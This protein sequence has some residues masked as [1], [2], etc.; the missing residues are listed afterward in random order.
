MNKTV[1]TGASILAL[2]MA[3]AAFAQSAPTAPA[4][5]TSPPTTAPTPDCTGTSNNCSNVTQDGS[6]LYATVD[7]SGEGNTSDIDQINGSVGDPTRDLG[8]VVT[9]SGTD[10]QS[11]VLQDNT[12]GANNPSQVTV[13]QDGTG[14]DS[15]VIQFESSND[16]VDVRQTGDNTSL[17]Y[18]D[19]APFGS[20][21]RVEI[22]Q[23]GGDLNTSTVFQLNTNRSSVGSPGGPDNGVIQNG[24]RNDSEVYQ[25]VS[26]ATGFNFLQAKVI[27]TGDD[28]NSFISQSNSG[29]VN[30]N[31]GVFPNVTAAQVEQVGNFNISSVVQTGARGGQS[32]GNLNVGVLQDG[33]DNLSRIEQT[34]VSSINSQASIA[35]VTQ[36]QDGND[37]FI[38]QSSGSG[39][40]NVTQTSDD[41]SGMVSG[42]AVAN[43]I[44]GGTDDVRANFSRVI[45]S[46]T[47]RTEAT[48]TQTGLG[49]LSDIRQNA[50]GTVAD[51]ASQA[52]VTQNGEDQSSFI[53]QNGTNDIA[54]VDQIGGARNVSRL[55]QLAGGVGNEAN[56]EQFG[57]D[58]ES[59][60]EQSGTDNTAN[61]LQAAMTDGNFSS[62]IQSGSENTANVFQTSSDNSSF[63]N[64]SGTNSTANVT[65]GPAPAL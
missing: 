53:E 8:V 65:Q 31:G 27:Q 12:G 51:L 6:D 26:G 24:N 4:A 63:V 11:Y 37:S 32:F 1:L 5:P 54:F 7:Q 57:S 25:G 50:P 10:N 59:T 34:N 60:V 2:S 62:I 55:Q 22:D 15:I 64:Q 9:Q 28:N 58:G 41:T 52:T 43:A 29:S 46:G 14:A 33:D 13:L 18:Q 39:L 45:Q 19:G 17:V 38:Q 30:A 49:N 23:F 21:S 35:N 20:D 42:T 16:K 48:L 47:G 56:I 36:N 3:G 40:I 44:S 61:L